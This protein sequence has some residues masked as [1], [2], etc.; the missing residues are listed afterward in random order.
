[1]LQALNANRVPGWQFPAHYLGLAFGRLEGHHAE[2]VMRA[3]PHCIDANGAVSLEALGVLADVAM[4][5]AVRSQMGPTARVAT[6]SIRLSLGILPGEGD[7][8]A[9]AELKLSYPGP[10]MQMTAA[11]LSVVANG[12]LCCTG[13]GTF[14]VLDSARNS[15]SHPLPKRST[16]ESIDPLATADLTSEERLVFDR[17]RY[18]DT[19]SLAEHPFLE[20]FW[21]AP[22][23]QGKEWAER[24]VEGGMHVGNRVGDIQGGVLLGIAARTC[25]S[26][27]PQGWRLIDLSAQYISASPHTGVV[28]RAKSLRVGRSLACIECEATDDQGRTTLRAQASF[29]KEPNS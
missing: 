21:S 4:A 15:A 2:V 24:R 22:S 18:A 17:A 14:A 16:L 3:G 27:L 29:M 5:G 26:A 9:A 11:S 12:K 13:E 19:R 23:G 7:L 6:V 8:H 25:S 10:A 20:R 28:I 1:M